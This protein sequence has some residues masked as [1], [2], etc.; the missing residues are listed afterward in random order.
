MKRITNM[1]IAA[2]G[3]I[4]AGACII[5]CKTDTDDS[6]SG[7]GASY[8]ELTNEYQTY[9][10]SI[11]DNDLSGLEGFHLKNLNTDKSVGMTIDKIFASDSMSEDGSVAVFNFDSPESGSNYWGFGA[12]T[13]ADGCWSSGEVAAATEPADAPE[14]YCTGFATSE[15]ASH[16]YVGVVVKNLSDTVKGDDMAFV[17][18]ISGNVDTDKAKTFREFFVTK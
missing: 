15:F 17:P 4:F 2:A 7:S 11:A 14:T 3:I 12:G 5:G 1:I 18:I 6:S 8:K 16:A 9:Y 13:I 10:L